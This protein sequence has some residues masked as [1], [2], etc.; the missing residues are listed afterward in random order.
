MRPT[1]NPTQPRAISNSTLDD[2]FHVLGHPQITNKD[3][4]IQLETFQ[5]YLAVLFFLR[6]SFHFN[7][8]LPKGHFTN[9]ND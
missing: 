4:S 9:C 5:L 1:T 8:T 7:Y 6:S 3:D 2:L